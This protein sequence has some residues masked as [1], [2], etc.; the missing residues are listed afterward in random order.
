MTSHLGHFQDWSDL[1][2]RFRDEPVDG[3]SSCPVSWGCHGEM[4][5]DVGQRSSSEDVSAFDLLHGF[6]DFGLVLVGLS[7][8]C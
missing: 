8:A 7:K 3:T 5:G 2:P 1:R 6:V 4:V